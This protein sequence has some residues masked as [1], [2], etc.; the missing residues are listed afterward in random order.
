MER[1]WRSAM[2]NEPSLTSPPLPAK[3]TPDPQA[4]V[5]C[6]GDNGADEIHAGADAR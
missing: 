2:V 3:L 4:A 5:V 6:G 1:A